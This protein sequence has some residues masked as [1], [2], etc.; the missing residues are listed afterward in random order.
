MSTFILPTHQDAL[1]NH[2]ADALAA[3]RA[4]AVALFAAQQRQFVVQEVVK[5]PGVSARAMAR[6][7]RMLLA[8][9]RNCEAHSPSQAAE[10][11]NLASRG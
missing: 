10:L 5:K 9:A 7:R 3:A 1:R 6:S 4:F 2:F 8:M 11:R